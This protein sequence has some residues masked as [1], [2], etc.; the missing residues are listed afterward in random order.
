MI[1]DIGPDTIALYKKTLMGA[2]TVVW[3]GPIGAFEFEK[4][5]E[6]TNE[7]ALFL[8]GLK[9]KVIIGGGDSAVA[10]KQLGLES[11]ITYISTGGGA[12]LQFLSGK[13]LPAI[14]ALE[15]SAS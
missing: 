1:G 10:I 3:S 6:G 4:F 15:E 8:S 14:N 13:K 5:S 11:E 9:A 7:I 12:F 2:K